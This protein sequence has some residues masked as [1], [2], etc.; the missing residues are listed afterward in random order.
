MLGPLCPMDGEI[1]IQDDTIEVFLRS[2]KVIIRTTL[3]FSPILIKSTQMA[4]FRFPQHNR[5]LHHL[6]CTVGVEHHGFSF[7]LCP[8]CI[9]SQ[10]MHNSRNLLLNDNSARK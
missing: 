3:Y 9:F 6:N 4:G 10:K 8:I 7:N 1:V 2:I 5:S